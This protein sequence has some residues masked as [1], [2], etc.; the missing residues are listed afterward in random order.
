[1]QGEKRLEHRQF[2]GAISILDAA[3]QLM[4]S[5]ASSDGIEHAQAAVSAMLSRVGTLLAHAFHLQF[6]LQLNSGSSLQYNQ[7]FAA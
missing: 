6:H 1:M 3:Y 2:E 7:N 5:L 4:S